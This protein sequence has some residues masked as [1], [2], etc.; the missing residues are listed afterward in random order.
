MRADLFLLKQLV[1]LTNEAKAL[2]AEAPKGGESSSGSPRQVPS[3]GVRGNTSF[4][5]RDPYSSV[6]P[7]S[8]RGV[9]GSG[10]R[11]RKGSQ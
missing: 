6:E 8:T 1:T 3:H 11:S 2:E 7:I 9:A 10:S 5:H 4:G